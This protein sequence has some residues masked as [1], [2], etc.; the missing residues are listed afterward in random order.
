M[1]AEGFDPGRFFRRFGGEGHN[2]LVGLLYE[3][4]SPGRVVLRLPWRADLAPDDA[5]ETFAEGAIMTALD[6]AATL[7]VW[8]RLGG[9]LPIATIDM[10]VDHL[11]SPPRGDILAV[12]ECYHHTPALAYLRGEARAEGGEPFATLASVFKITAGP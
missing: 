1:S 3:T 9:R 10:R 5:G 12:A 11:K 7:A 8:S 6:M 2:G 4:H